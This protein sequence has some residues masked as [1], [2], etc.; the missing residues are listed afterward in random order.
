MRLGAKPAIVVFIV[1]WMCAACGQGNT[2]SPVAGNTAEV[3]ASVTDVSAPVGCQGKADCAALEDGNP[4]NGTL[5]CDKGDGKCKINPASVVDCTASKDTACRQNRCNP[6]DGQCELKNVAQS[7]PCDDG[8][9][10][11]VETRCDK[12]ECIGKSVCACKKDGDCAGR[13][14]GDLCKGTLY[15]DTSEVPYGCK[16]N[17]S[18]R[19]DCSDA[20]DTACSQ[21]ACDPKL[22]KCAMSAVAD[23]TGCTSD[24]LACTKDSCQTGMCKAA[25]SGDDCQCANDAECQ[26]LD[27]NKCDGT[28]YCNLTKRVCEPVPASAVYCPMLYQGPCVQ[29]VCNTKTGQCEVKTLADGAACDDGTKCGDKTGCVAGKCVAKASKCQCKSSA[30]C[31]AHEDGDPCNGILYCDKAKGECVVNPGTIVECPPGDQDA[32]RS[33]QCD[34]KTGQCALLPVNDGGPCEYDGTPCT[35]ID[36]C[37]AGKCVKPG[38]NGCECLEDADCAK[39]DDGNACNGTL[40]CDKL[41]GKCKLNPSTKVVCAKPGTTCLPN[42]CDKATGVCKPTAK[43]DGTVCDNDG[44]ACTVD[45]CKSG[46]CQL[47]VPACQ[48]SVEADCAVFDDGNACNGTLVCDAS[49]KQPLCKIDPATTGAKACDDGNACTT[50]TCDGSTGKCGH[51]SAKD[52]TVCGIGQGCKAGKCEGSF[53]PCT[54]TNNDSCDTAIDINKC[55]G[56]KMSATLQGKT[57]WYNKSGNTWRPDAW[58]L[59]KPSSSAKLSVKITTTDS[60]MKFSQVNWKKEAKWACPCKSPVE[61]C[62]GYYSGGAS[63]GT[64]KKSCTFNI[65]VGTTYYI[66]FYSP[67][68]NTDFT[69]TFAKK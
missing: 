20:K 65:S 27:T 46:T 19:V 63:C 3:Q 55:L 49:G 32:C 21:A 44:M 18:T 57:G 13:E 35:S 31:V 25:G 64:G 54:A 67:S 41:A 1:A 16:V 28:M 33:N 9:P 15:C 47:S 36:T 8:E 62:N 26:A 30:D 61:K 37:V 66:V 58:Y 60:K 39:F 22:G 69:V 2:A 24:W 48:C 12:G 43:P 14:D 50:D 5:Y 7:K 51:A 6:S 56:V 10:C 68:P 38:D 4:C 17:P 11:T 59:Y 42:R 23:D 29:N 40:Y 53:D 45:R 34:K 52:G